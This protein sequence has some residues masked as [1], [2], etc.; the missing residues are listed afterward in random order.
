MKRKIL[1]SKEQQNNFENILDVRSYFLNYILNNKI[2][3]R[4]FILKND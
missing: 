2:K 4:E 3:G 1:K